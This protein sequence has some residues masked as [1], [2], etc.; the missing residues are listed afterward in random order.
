MSDRFSFS[1]VA[2]QI[3]K[4]LEEDGFVG[5][6][7]DNHDSQGRFASGSGGG[8]SEGGSGEVFRQEGDSKL[9]RGLST[10]MKLSAATAGD[11]VEAG[12]TRPPLC[13]HIARS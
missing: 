2:D 3:R 9:T 1:K 13:G 11:S 7:N 6:A 12:L 8:K 5:K 4:G 10:A